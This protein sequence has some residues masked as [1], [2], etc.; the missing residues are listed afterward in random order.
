M[1]GILLRDPMAKV[2]QG[3]GM[4]CRRGAATDI[5]PTAAERD[6]SHRA[7]VFRG[8]R[9]PWAS[10]DVERRCYRLYA[11]AVL[12]YSQTI[13]VHDQE[14]ELGLLWDDDIEDWKRYDSKM[15][16][17]GN[18]EVVEVPAF[19]GGAPSEAMVAYTAWKR[20]SQKKGDQEPE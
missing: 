11:H 4:P 7:K 10:G 18:V 9:T 16:E 20:S 6:R 3:T 5:G 17:N 2:D 19:K 13:E 14:D 12:G 15:D 1:S 8:A